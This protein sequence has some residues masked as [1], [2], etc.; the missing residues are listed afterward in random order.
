MITHTSRNRI[1]MELF[2]VSAQFPMLR[3][4]NNIYRSTECVMNMSVTVR[5]RGCPV[6]RPQ[7]DTSCVVLRCLQQPSWD[8]PAHRG[9]VGDDVQDEF[10]VSYFHLSRL[11]ASDSSVSCFLVPSVSSLWP[12]SV[13]GP[14]KGFTIVW[15]HIHLVSFSKLKRLHIRLILC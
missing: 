13:Y 12:S 6:C 1:S 10:L 15:P 8:R 4:L 11:F 14:L 9:W 3:W 5:V 7:A 2:W